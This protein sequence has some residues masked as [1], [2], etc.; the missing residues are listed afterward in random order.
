MPSLPT[1]TKRARVTK[2]AVDDGNYHVAQVDYMGKVCDVEISTPYGLY[3]SLP[4][5]A[6]TVLWNIQGQEENRVGIGN[7]PTTRFKNLE[8]GEVVIGSPQTLSK[9]KFATDGSITVTGKNNATITIDA[10]GNMTATT[11]GDYT[12]NATGDVI[13]NGATIQLN[14]NAVG[15]A[16]LN[17]NVDLVTGEIITASNTVKTA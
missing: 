16:R 12:I 10:S 7:T 2:V 14:G 6:V 17:D 8:A 1:A 9:V 5:D 3:S 13:I 15:V 4:A 11:G